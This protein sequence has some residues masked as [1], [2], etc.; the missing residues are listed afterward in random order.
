MEGSEGEG[1]NCAAIARMG[2]TNSHKSLLSQLRHATLASQPASLPA[3]LP[4]SQ[5]FSIDNASA[6]LLRVFNL[7]EGEHYVDTTIV[8]PS[9]FIMRNAINIQGVSL[10]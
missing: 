3:C 5:Q 2:T 8:S 7:Q 4:A 10:N 6:L 1:R 9:Q